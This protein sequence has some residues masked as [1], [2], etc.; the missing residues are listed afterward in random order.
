MAKPVIDAELCIGCGACVE[1]C[2]EV[3]EL[4]DDKAVVIGP[5]KCDACKC[6]E[7]VSVCPVEAISMK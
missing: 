4:Q 6:D 2:P 1:L 3:F 5:D 7:A